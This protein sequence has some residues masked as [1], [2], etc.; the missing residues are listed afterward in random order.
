MKRSLLLMLTGACTCILQAQ[1]VT[2]KK[3]IHTI[4]PYTAKNKSVMVYTTADN[5]SYRLT[6][7]ATLTFKEHQQPIET[8]ACIFDDPAKTF[9]SYLG[10]GGALTDASAETFYK[11]PKNKQQEI[12]NAYYNTN[13]GIGYT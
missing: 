10:I 11:L 3:H 2:I 6:K 8:E 7:T 9:Q 13:T 4:A 5:T 1:A 12:L